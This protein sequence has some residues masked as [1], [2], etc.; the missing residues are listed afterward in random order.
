[1]TYIINSFYGNTWIY[2][3]GEGEV[4]WANNKFNTYSYYMMDIYGDESAKWWEWNVICK[5]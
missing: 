2:R 4:N 1:M 3:R 5:M